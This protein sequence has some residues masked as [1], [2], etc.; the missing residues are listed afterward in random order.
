[1][2]D[3]NSQLA[4]V[5]TIIV[6]AVIVLLG[7]VGFAAY[8]YFKGKSNDNSASTNKPATTSSN[9]TAKTQG[10]ESMNKFLDFD[11]IVDSMIVRKK[12]QQYVMVIDCKG[13]NY[14]L[15]G[16]DEKISIENGFTQFLNTLKFPV[17]LYIQTRSLN[18]KDSID[19]YEEK[20]ETIKEQII[21]LDAQIKKEKANGRN[22]LV[23]KLEFDRKRKMNILE[24]GMDITEYISRMSQNRNVLQQKTYVIV[25]YYTSE[26]GGEIANY[27]KEEVNNI[28]FGEL[29]TRAQTLIRSLASSGVTGK[30]I[31]SE[32]L[33]ELLY[34]AYNRDDSELINIRKCVDA[35]YDSLYS[36]ARDLMDKQKEII[37]SKIEEEALTLAAKS[38]TRAD[39]IRKF[40]QEKKEE[41]KRRA[42]EYVEE[43]KN[44]MTED[45]YTET[46]R[47]IEK[48]DLEE[49]P[50]TKKVADSEKVRKK[51][52]VAQTSKKSATT[53][54]EP[55]K[56]AK[57]VRPTVSEV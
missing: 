3:T 23:R 42:L 48:A 46:K 21:K 13:V 50:K 54:T 24:Y 12:G 5:Y 20:I 45:L 1:M 39:K 40:R 32:E 19:N 16:A 49:K 27:S 43:Y 55:K 10:I 14:D 33:A 29:Y 8:V 47:Q 22:D 41:I 44:E 2:G 56:V 36:T 17:Q 4:I 35:Q 9:A 6:I 15:L 53:E 57:K 7:V 26:F 28:A 31:N 34:I 52:A 25:T 11:E 37:E 30:V 51:K 38:V 18:L